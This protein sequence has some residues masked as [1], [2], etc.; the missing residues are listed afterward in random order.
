MRYGW[1]FCIGLSVLGWI[2]A[3]GLSKGEGVSLLP[4]PFREG[5]SIREVQQAAI[6]Y[7]EVP[8][9][10]IAR[11]R[12]LART[13]ALLPRFTI[14]LDQGKNRTVA[15]ATSNGK[16]TFSVGPEDQSLKL[17]F[18]FTWDL[19]DLVWST[20]QL[21]IDGR[22]RLLVKLRNETLDEVTKVYFERQ[23]LRAEFQGN[24]T[25]DEILQKERRL[26][27]EELTARLDALT[28]GYFS[29]QET[30]VVPK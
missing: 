5:P 30:D 12:V 22:S 10:K 27:M 20:D 7:A 1:V 23:R 24:P 29:V 6:R 14:N 13:R 11:W 18:D 8:A 26:R 19:G 4:D 3:Q 28:G 25:D 9:E 2:A 16:T 15:S 17:G 21:S